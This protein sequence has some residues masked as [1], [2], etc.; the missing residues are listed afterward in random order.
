MQTDH[1]NIVIHLPAGARP[2]GFFPAE[3]PAVP[4]SAEHRAIQPAATIVQRILLTAVFGLSLIGGI[5]LASVSTETLV[6][7]VIID[8][9]FYYVVPAQHLL[10]GKGYSFDGELRTNGVQPL[11]AA[12]V[13]VLSV[14]LPHNTAILHVVVLLSGLF[15]IGA[16]AILYR[17]LSKS[18]PWFALLVASGWLL[19]GFWNRLAFQGMENGLY[20]FVFAC[21]L[22]YGIRY[23]RLPSD[24]AAELSAI[25]RT[26]MCRR[27]Q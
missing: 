1:R 24:L 12:I 3:Y 7:R 6:A 26:A 19:T 9:A 10:E 21:I 22:A 5:R 17:A 18:N 2:V 25:T 11:W 15:W 13:V 8:D 14:I 27:V 23:L 20:G 4:S 16:G